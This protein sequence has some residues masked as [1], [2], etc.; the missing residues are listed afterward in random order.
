MRKIIEYDCSSKG[1][2]LVQRVKRY[3]AIGL[4]LILAASALS[5]CGTVQ[6]EEREVSE[7][8]ISGASAEQAGKD[9]ENGLD[10][11]S[12]N[13]EKP[14]SQKSEKESGKADEKEAEALI[15]TVREQLPS[16]KKNT[17][18]EE[19]VYV[20]A[21][22][23]GS[24]EEEIA[25]VWLKNPDKEATLTDSTEL[26]DVE[27]VKGEE[28][29]TEDNDGRMVWQADGKDIYYQ[30]KTDKELP[31][32]TEITYT[33]DGNP[34]Q[35]DELAGKSGHLKIDFSYINHE[36]EE[37]DVNGKTV[38]LS[39]PFLVF[40]ALPLENNKAANVSVTN[41]KLINTGD[42][43]IVVGYAMPGMTDSLKACLPDAADRETQSEELPME[44]PESVTVEADVTDFSLLTTMTIIDNSLLQELDLDDVHTMD[45]LEKAV[46][47]LGDASGKLKEGSSELADGV[48]EL[49]DKTPELTSGI[50]ALDQGAAALASGAGTLASG[51]G[52]VNDGAVKLADGSRELNNGAAEVDSG[53][54]KLDQGAEELYSGTDALQS[55]TGEL[56]AGAE[57]L[58][59]GAAALYAG[60]GA[61]ESGA[62]QLT[63]GLGQL[64][65]RVS[66]LP[67]GSEKLAEGARQVQ[68]ALKGSEGNSVYEGLMEIQNGSAQLTAGLKSGNT[69]Q[70]GIYEAAQGIESGAGSIK[71]A[72]E[73]ISTAS[74]GI[75]DGSTQIS[76]GSEGLRAL[77]GMAYSQLGIIQEKHPAEAAAV[78]EELGQA[79]QYLNAIDGGITSI[80]KASGQI[81]EVS[82][83][84]TEGAGKS[85]GGASQIED[86]AG[87]VAGYAEQMAGGAQKLEEGTGRLMDGIDTIT[88]E[89]NMGALVNGLEELS[90]NS[91]ALVSGV[92]QLST[93][94]SQL[95][96]GIQDAGT[97]AGE[98]AKGADSLA[99]GAGK[100]D[101][102][103]KQLNAGA[104]ALSEGI[105]SLSEGTGKLA[106]GSGALAAGA[107]E[108]AKGTGTLA[109]GSNTLSAGAGKL[110]TGT[111]LLTSG[112][113][114]LTEGVLQLLA[115]AKQLRDGM[116]EFD[117]EGIEKLTSYVEDDAEGLIDGLRAIRKL[118]DSYTG[119]SGGTEGSDGSVQF[120]I[121]TEAIG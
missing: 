66:G 39:K 8:T 105:G 55:G 90:N 120:I 100:T 70:P 65:S 56:A 92:G 49:A 26:S 111:N 104:E 85:E 94:A 77:L 107:G 115:G 113:T 16:G 64:S 11:G 97:G 110:Y 88:N 99:E 72:A 37:A 36:K 46:E 10:E 52:Q 114:Q 24:A 102:G 9:N 1:T 78:A 43:T 19:T 95:Q 118:G 53:T 15:D 41:G 23:G 86:A 109:E 44:L 69:E 76:S 20:V 119:F 6:A 62:S 89:E 35:P 5:A 14:D 7:E 45:D 116:T 57:T 31:V 112:S 18:R 38:M 33:L 79:E 2:G 75:T 54:K 42:K 87:T 91:Q 106:A 28:T 12:E 61:L 60:T 34:V 32:T 96:K 47:E 117:K 21:D 63:D 84:I 40:S 13:T 3:S 74:Q 71:T 121:R 67:E 82:G 58:A 93:G 30:G 4:S 108:L 80:N 27:N 103:A 59:G 73:Q 22:A 48:Q 17:E 81:S 101:E 29:F 25:S 51:A 98:L 50:S 83:E 68:S